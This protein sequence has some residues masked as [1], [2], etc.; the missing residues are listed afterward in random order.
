MDIYSLMFFGKYN[1]IH[2]AK[3]YNH[4]TGFYDDLVGL[5]KRAFPEKPLDEQLD[6]I[7]DLI[8]SYQQMWHQVG[9][10]DLERQD[11]KFRYPLFRPEHI[12]P[13]ENLDDYISARVEGLHPL[14]ADAGHRYLNE[15]ICPLDFLYVLKQNMR[16]WA[17]GMHTG[18]SEG[19]WCKMQDEFARMIKPSSLEIPTSGQFLVRI[20]QHRSITDFSNKGRLIQN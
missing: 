12:T 4:N 3:V 19:D 13:N 1:F 14:F 5:G 18:S 6:E 11:K 9:N 17:L 8:L 16:E 2:T 20:Y 7:A 15:E 10:Q